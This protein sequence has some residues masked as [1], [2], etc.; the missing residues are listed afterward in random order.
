MIFRIMILL[1]ISTAKV[2]LV[3]FFFFGGG[4]W[5]GKLPFQAELISTKMCHVVLNRST[6]LLSSS[7]LQ[8]DSV[9]YVLT[10]YKRKRSFLPS[11]NV[12]YLSVHWITTS[13]TSI[14]IQSQSRNLLT[15]NPSM[16]NYHK[17]DLKFDK[18][19][20]N[21]RLKLKTHL[22]MKLQPKHHA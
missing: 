2:S 8:T 15:F 16:T 7:T 12:N 17:I 3:F 13:T 22:L 1:A 20:T 10:Q 6:N 18:D 9:F 21:W 19:Q 11:C 4:G 5:C 14:K